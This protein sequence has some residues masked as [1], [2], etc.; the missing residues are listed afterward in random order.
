MHT[1]VGN[2]VGSSRDEGELR[3]Y[4][5]LG[6]RFEQSS[7]L[8]SSHRPGSGSRR[9]V[10]VRAHWH[11]PDAWVLQQ[12]GIAHENAYIQHLESQGLSIVNLREVGNDEEA[13]A[14]TIAALQ[15]GQT[16][17]FRPPSLKVIGLA[18]RMYCGEWNVRATRRLVI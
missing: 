5:A 15:S 6:Q 12:R 17:S 4:P 8:P 2:R 14:D 1:I 11:S 10:G 7:C 16:L 9:L 18:G 3:K 13:V